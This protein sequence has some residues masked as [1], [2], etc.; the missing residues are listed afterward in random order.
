LKHGCNKGQIPDS[1]LEEME[2]EGVSREQVTQLLSKIEM[3]DESGVSMW[4]EEM[5]AN[6]EE[7]EV[8]RDFMEVLPSDI[9]PTTQELSENSR[10]E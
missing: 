3:L 2:K 10:V 9:M 5:E 1:L 4:E 6:S 8:W 7:G